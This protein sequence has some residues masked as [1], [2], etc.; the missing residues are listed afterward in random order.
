M[1]FLDISYGLFEL[2]KDLGVTLQAR[3]IPSRLNC[4]V[5]PLSRGDSVVNTEWTLCSRIAKI[6]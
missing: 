3:H 4:L 6:I 2:V 5:D 1:T